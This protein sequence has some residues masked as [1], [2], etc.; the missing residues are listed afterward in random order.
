MEQLEITSTTTVASSPDVLGRI[1]F[2]LAVLAL[3]LAPIQFVPHL[4]LA[5]SDL[6]L[7]LAGLVWAIRWI[8]KRDTGNLPP[9]ANW[10][11]IAAIGFSVIGVFT[12]TTQIDGQRKA[13]LIETAQMVLYLLVGVTVFRAAL[14]TPRRIRIAV[15][16]LL[17]AATFAVALGV[18]Q[19]GLL[20]GQ[21]Q[22]DALQRQ[23][24]MHFT[25]SAYLT[26]ETP[27]E[28]CST[29]GSW[30]DKGFHASRMGYAGF[31]GLVLPFALALLAGKPRRSFTT[32]WLAVLFLGA[33]VSV[34]AGY[35]V[36]SILIGLLVTGV[37]LGPRI[38][39]GVLL[40]VLLYAALVLVIGGITR[41]EIF[42]EP[43]RAKI[44]AVEASN[45]NLQYEGVRH[46]KKIWGEQIAAINVLRGTT[47]VQYPAL[48]G[49]G[50][51]QY[52][53]NIQEGYGGVSSMSNQ[54]LESESQSGYLLTMVSAGIFGLAA[55]CALFGTYLGQAWRLVRSRTPDP[56]AAALLGAMV[57]LTLMSVMTNPWVRGTSVVIAAIFALL[58]N[59]ATSAPTARIEN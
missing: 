46:L 31:L 43:L 20:Q 30:N 15:I 48:F 26:T 13:F 34:L 10:L 47:Y 45:P 42:Q 5:P 21:Y 7:A 59:R 24:F 16:A 18:V 51:G 29:F 40:G 33:A 12:D 11:L 55:L 58:C 49:A 8:I 35:L 22:P 41:T 4:P 39:R 28:V 23:V 32:A 9:F 36:P 3:A 53:K 56:W 14:T 50:T 1:V 25:P 2:G 57:T 17:A 19:R 27:I 44:S 6:L 38:G 54:R 37:A 52:Q